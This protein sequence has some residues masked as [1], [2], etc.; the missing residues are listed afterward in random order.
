MNIKK[1]EHF[2]RIS[3]GDDNHSRTAVTYNLLQQ[4][5]NPGI[6]VRSIALN[7]ERRQRSVVIKQQH[8]LGGMGHSL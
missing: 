2:I 8:S 7:V 6:R 4:E 3:P 1:K 5:C